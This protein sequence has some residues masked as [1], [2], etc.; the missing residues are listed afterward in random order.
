M[1]AKKPT[2]PTKA[3]LNRREALKAQR[4][5]EAKRR[6][7]TRIIAAIAGVVVLA[8]VVALIVWVANRKPATPPATSA[9]PSAEQ[10]APPHGSS[11][12]A[13]ITVPSDNTKADAPIV[14]IQFDYQCPVCAKFEGVYAT[15]FETLSDRGD[16]VLRYHTRTFL[17]GNLQNDASERAAVAA[18]CVDVADS[19]KYALYHNLL[20]TNQ[21]AEQA[22][23]PGFTDDQLTSVFPTAVGLTGDALTTFNT[24]YTNRQTLQFVRDVETNNI[25]AIANPSPPNAYLFGGNTPNTDTDGSCTGTAGTQIGTC[26]T[27]DFY[28]QGVRIS[29][30]DLLN[31]DWTPK[32]ADADALLALLRQLA[33]A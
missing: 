19:T 21:P 12:R 29:L 30:T 27:P 31:S 4:L 2:R 14:D 9:P 11:Q 16:I 6:R 15:M 22:G 33:Q 26:G 25:S 13:W 18:A 1:S 17:D 8:V 3:S 28:V 10:I 5:A 20:F 7:R 32:A 24:C 23:G